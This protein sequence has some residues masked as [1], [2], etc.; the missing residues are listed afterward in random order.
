MRHGGFELISAT[1][2]VHHR[3]QRPHG[4]TEHLADHSVTH[5]YD[6]VDEYRLLV[7]PLILGGGKRLFADGR[8]P[9]RLTLTA[10]RPTPSGVLIN[11]YRRPAEG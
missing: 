11:T 2:G 7:F 8:S 5:E 10:T 9:R 4:R 3:A 6:L 1:H